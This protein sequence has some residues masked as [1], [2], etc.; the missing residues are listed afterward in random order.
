MVVVI[1]GSN[2]HM[3]CLFVVVEFVLGVFGGGFICFCVGFL[4]S[5]CNILGDAITRIE[6]VIL[7]SK[8]LYSS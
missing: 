6:L 5:L 2:E 3:V 7:L 4:H 8:G 1:V